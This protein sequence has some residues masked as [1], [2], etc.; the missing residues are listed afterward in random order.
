[1]VTENSNHVWIVTQKSVCGC[2]TFPTTTCVYTAKKVSVLVLKHR[3]WRLQNWIGSQLHWD[4]YHKFWI[5]HLDSTYL[6]VVS[7]WS[8]W[9]AHQAVC[10]ERRQLQRLIWTRQSLELNLEH[11]SLPKSCR[12]SWEWWGLWFRQVGWMPKAGGSASRK[13]LHI[14][15]YH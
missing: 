1:M 10:A 13:K 14:G 6:T 3:F 7:D 5:Y 12:R 11:H 9:R 8:T 15:F 2:N 4:I